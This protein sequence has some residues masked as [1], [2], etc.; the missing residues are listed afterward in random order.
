MDSSSRPP[1][2]KSVIL[3]SVRDPRFITARRRGTMTDET[4]RLLALWAAACA[5]HGLGVPAYAI[6]QCAHQLD[7]ARAR[8]PADAS[9]S[10][11][12]ITSLIR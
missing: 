11:S 7:R 12:E 9:A 8:K 6:R 10:G 3:P 2:V 1:E 4:H 5:E